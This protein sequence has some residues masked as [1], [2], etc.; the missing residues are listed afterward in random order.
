MKPIHD[1]DD[2]VSVTLFTHTPKRVQRMRYPAFTLL[3][4][5]YCHSLSHCHKS[6]MA[7]LAEVTAN[8]QKNRFTVFYCH[9]Y[10]AEMTAND[11]APNRAMSLILGLLKASG[12][13]N[14]TMANSAIP[15][16]CGVPS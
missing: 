5:F 10:D 1:A 13:A 4:Y 2:R 8:F 9:F 3:L 6:V 15:S 7:R 16:H 12:K 11:S 14:P